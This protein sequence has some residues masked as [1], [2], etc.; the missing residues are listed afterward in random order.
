MTIRK[1][2]LTV[3]VDPELVEAGHRAVAGGDADSLSGWVSRALSEKVHRDRRLEHLRAAI[4][5]YEA[6]FG[7]ITPAEITTQR[8][9][10][11]EN[12]VVVRGR[13]A[14][15]AEPGRRVKKSSA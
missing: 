9:A 4:A 13:R 12:A 1:K 15:D 14:S 8:R 2:R 3:T 5:D 10:D 6:E 7:E 11:R